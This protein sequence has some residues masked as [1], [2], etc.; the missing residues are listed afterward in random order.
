[1]AWTAD[2][3]KAINECGKNIIVSAGAGSGKTAVLTERVITKLKKGININELLILTF[4]NAAAMEMKDRIREAITKD[5]SLHS[6]LDLIDGSYITTFDSFALSIVKKYHYLLNIPKDISILDNEI[7]KNIKTTFLDEV[8]ETLYEQKDTDF[9]KMVNDLPVIDDTPLRREILSLNEL[10]ERLPEKEEYLNNYVN[11]FYNEKNIESIVKNF[12]ELINK[13]V[14]KIKIYL[15]NLS[16]NCDEKYYEKVINVVNPILSAKTYE[17][18]KSYTN[19]KVPALPKNSEEDLKISKEKLQKEIDSLHNILIY[20]D[21]KHIKNCLL[22]TITYAKAIIKII[23]RLDEKV[24]SYKEKYASFEF[25]D[26]AKMAIKIAKTPNAKKELSSSF[27]EIMVDEYQD[28]SDLQETLVNLISNNNV[29]MVGDIKQSIYRFRNANPLIFKNKY[30]KYSKEDGGIK[31]DLLKNFRSRDKVLENINK[32]FNLLMDDVFGG[33]NYKE[34]HQ[35]VFGNTVYSENS[36]NTDDLDVFVY[37]KEDKKYSDTEYEAFIIA[38]DIKEKLLSGYKVLDKE[39]KTLRPCKYDDFCILIDRK[40]GFE[41]YKKIF[42]YLDLPLLIYYDEKI[43]NE[44]DILVLKNLIDLIVCIYNKDY[45]QK[46][47]YDFYSILR[48]F[49]YNE[50]DEVFINYFVNNNYYNSDLFKKCDNIAK[51]LDTMSSKKLIET[52]IDEFDFYEKAILIGD[53]D[54]VI[55]RC[56]YL[57]SLADN[58]SSLGKSIIEFNEYLNDL[59]VNDADISFTVNTNVKNN[60]KLMNI[61]KS[62]GLEFPICYFAGFDKAFNKQD[63]NKMFNFDYDLGLILPFYDDG[64]GPTIL[65]S[66]YKDKYLKEDISERIRLFYVALTRAKEKMIMVI[67]NNMEDISFKE[68]LNSFL[69][70]ISLVKFVLKNNIKYINDVVLTKNYNYTKEKDLFEKNNDLLNVEEIKVNS[71]LITHSN[72]SKKVLKLLTKEEVNA[73]EYGTHIHE[74]F[75]TEDFRNANNKYVLALLEKIDNNFKNVY[76]EYEFIY[77]YEDKEYEGIIDLLLEYEDKMVII[78]YK[79]SNIDDENYVKQLSIYKSFIENKT[80]KETETYLYSIL[81]DTLKKI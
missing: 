22:E 5:E 56:D 71:N 61:H 49:L 38:G 34:S 78:D 1:M 8:F 76:K 35:M 68:D 52:I 10:I 20:K 43:T 46:F 55:K 25:N 26:V 14:N 80:K 30:D 54:K 64:V 70:F 6:Q 33:A 48:S 66:I 40:N 12:Y 53:I 45:K 62:K 58:L 15:D 3:E 74:I 59:I 4:T 18:Y 39:T 16:Y 31:I 17:E 13:K 11:N 77:K 44:K 73:M 7:A 67:P 75:E 36:V 50:K 37:N 23:N 60:I 63:L 28:T 72:V 24:L 41:I 21:E 79:L 81:N 42:E 57:L 47:K 27:K 69:T 19:V 2:Q 51:K 29:Y 32:I 65:K 9:L